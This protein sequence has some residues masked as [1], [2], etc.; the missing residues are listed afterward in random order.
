MPLPPVA[1]PEVVDV[2][3]PL[4][5]PSL[6]P[7]APRVEPVAQLSVGDPAATPL[8]GAD[9]VVLSAAKAEALDRT[10]AADK[11]KTLFKVFILSPY[12]PF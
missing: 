4:P 10:S 9:G 7:E 6:R 5:V 11:I 2:V 12:I 8:P 1:L 3:V